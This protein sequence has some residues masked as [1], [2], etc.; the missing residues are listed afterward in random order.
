M[1]RRHALAYLLL[2]LCLVYIFGRATLNDM[3]IIEARNVCDAIYT[4]G[5]PDV[6][7]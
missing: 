3:G 2:A 1:K 4:N 5:V 6:V 7:I